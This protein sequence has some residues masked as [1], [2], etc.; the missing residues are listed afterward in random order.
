MTKEEKETKTKE[1]LALLK[2]LNFKDAH[3][4]LWQTMHLSKQKAIITE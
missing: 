4:I 3:D 2:G 1:I